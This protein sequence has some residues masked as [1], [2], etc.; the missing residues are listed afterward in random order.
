[1]N[2][3]VSE[4]ITISTEIKSLQKQIKELKESIKL[5]EPEIM[6]YMSSIQAD[7]VTFKGES[8]VLYSKTT[9]KKPS[10]DEVKERVESKLGSHGAEELLK[11]IRE[12]VSEVTEER[13][14]VVSKR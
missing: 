6:E 9:K 1:M 7:S 11:T 3:S 10:K 14:K 12:P 8:I 13:L 5:L 2:K 4:F